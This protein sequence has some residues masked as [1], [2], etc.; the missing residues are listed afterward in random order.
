MHVERRTVLQ[1]SG[2]I[3]VGGLVAA[4]SGGSDA[5]ATSSAPGSSAAATGAASPTAAASSAAA[6]S[7]AAGA[8][9]Q[10]S[11]IPVGSGLIIA[12]PAVV[13]THPEDGTIK[14]FSAICTHQGCLV[15]SVEDNEIICPCHNSRFSATDGSVIQGPATVALPEETITV[16]DNGLIAS[17]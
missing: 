12:D 17:A 10:V 4:C 7:A 3:A 6:S 8:L 5:A 9:A 13:I 14:A 15:G 16:D 11:D 2:L 1:A